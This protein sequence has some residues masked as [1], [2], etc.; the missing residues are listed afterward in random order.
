[1]ANGLGGATGSG[2]LSGAGMGAKIG[3]AIAPGVGTAIG[4]GVGALAGGI[5]GRSK[6]KA[7]NKAQEIPLVD[8]AERARLAQLDQT[9]KNLAQGSDVMT[10]Q[11]LKQQQN[12]G[13]GAQTALSRSTAGDVGGTMDALLRSQKATQGG[14]NQTIAQSA[15]RLPYFDSA[16]GGLTSR[17]AQRKLE[18]GL[19]NRSQKTA[20]SA[21]GRTDSNINAQA[22]LATE[23][24]LQTIPEGM[25][26][27]AQQA[28]AFMGRLGSIGSGVKAGDFAATQEAPVP[29]AQ[30]PILEDPSLGQIQGVPSQIG[31]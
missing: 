7:A 12:V 29:T 26:Q 16:T 10:Q 20:E 27:A 3:S 14:M 17:I 1:M 4:A 11:A 13:K 8:P 15:N 21:Q 23:G 25:T 9:R 30:Q 22:L 31:I 19:L 2:A 28:Q 6:Q 5:S 24:G 18:L